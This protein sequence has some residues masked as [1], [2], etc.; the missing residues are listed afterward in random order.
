MKYKRDLF[1][2]AMNNIG[3][4]IYLLLALCLMIGLLAR[5]GVNETSASSLTEVA[6]P[7]ETVDKDTDGSMDEA[8]WIELSHKLYEVNQ[9]DVLLENHSSVKYSFTYPERPKWDNFYWETS[10]CFYQE[11]PGLTYA[12]YDKERIYYVMQ[13]YETGAPTLS[14]GLDLTSDYDPFY[15]VM[16]TSEDAFFDPEHEHY[17]GSY[18]E[19]GQLHILTEYD[20]KGGR[21]WVESKLDR[22]YAGEILHGEFVAD[23]VT[24]EALE[25]SLYLEKDGETWLVDRLTV[26]YDTAEPMNCLTLRSYF[27]HQKNMTAVV[28]PGSGH[29]CTV[30][31]YVPQNSIVDIQADEPWLAFDDA[32]CTSLSATAKWDGL[33]DHSVVVITDPDEALIDRY[34]ALA[35]EAVKER[36]PAMETDKITMEALASANAMDAVFSHHQSVFCTVGDHFRTPWCYYYEPGLYYESVYGGGNTYLLDGKGEWHLLDIDGESVLQTIWLAATEEEQAAALIPPEAYSSVIN[37]ESTERETLLDVTDNGDGTVTVTTRMMDEDVRTKLEEYG[38]EYSS[39]M[40]IECEY[41]AAADTLEILRILEY[42][43][44]GEER[45]LFL[46]SAICYDEAPPEKATVLQ[47]L[48]ADYLTGTAADTRTL[49]VIYDAGTDAEET[50]E[51]TTP[52]NV[53]VGLHFRAGYDYQ[54]AD[55]ERTV[56]GIVPDDAGNCVIYAFSER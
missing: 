17:V 40:S 31:I 55:P 8:A 4:R 16:P 46:V 35:A 30:S 9:L 39:D 49:T 12:R 54:Y 27:E 47:E 7:A 48:K 50:F 43:V 34:N 44:V 15:N 36:G 22:E 5:C 11:W 18:T 32:E 28:D 52:Q 13:E 25:N 45:S 2:S 41:L 51:L 24:N 21:D 1:F 38:K 37:P 23:A 3:K 19:N 20:E 56:P 6:P 10:E 14:C 33:S 42:L 53:K 29:E 26:E